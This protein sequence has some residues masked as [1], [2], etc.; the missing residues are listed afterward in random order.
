MHL[1][2]AAS[3]STGAVSFLLAGIWVCVLIGILVAIRWSIKRLDALLADATGAW[4]WV[5]GILLAALRLVFVMYVLGVSAL[6]FSL[7][8]G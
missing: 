3:P 8:I 2:Q 1:S 6:I 4:A 5:G 7:M